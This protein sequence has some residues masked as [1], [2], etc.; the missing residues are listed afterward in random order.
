VF[1]LILALAASFLRPGEGRQLVLMQPLVIGLVQL[2]A[3][4][5]RFD[6]NPVAWLL[7]GAL[8]AASLILAARRAEFRFAPPVAL[9]LALLLILAKAL[10]DDD[11]LVPFVA[12][13]TTLMFAGVSIPLSRTDCF[14]RTLTACGALAGPILILRVLRPELLPPA[15]WGLTAALLS[16]GALALLWLHRAP[17]GGRELPELALAVAAV[18]AAV[19][20][21]TAGHDLT[22]HDFVSA[23]WLAVALALVAAG[24]RLRDKPLRL[25]GLILLTATILKVFLLDAAALS[26]VLRIRS[27]LGLGVALIGMGKLYGTVLRAERKVRRGD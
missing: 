4:V 17:S 1:A 5:I 19:L 27:F 13:A 20:L 2:A 24:I 14:S 21:A 10:V 9:A 11:P 12:A 7:F 23:T 16:L 26:G 15:G 22:P 8:S 3:L 25:A 18:T 6:S